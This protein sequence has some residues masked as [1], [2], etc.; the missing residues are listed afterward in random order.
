MCTL[1][2]CPWLSE[3][4]LVWLT[5][6]GRNSVVLPLVVTTVTGGGK[7]MYPETLYCLSTEHVLS[8]WGWLFPVALYG[9]TSLHYVP[10]LWLIS[11]VPPHN[12][13]GIL[14]FFWHACTSK[15]CIWRSTSKQVRELIF[16]AVSVYDLLPLPFSRLVIFILICCWCFL[17]NNSAIGN[18]G[19]V[20]LVSTTR[21]WQTKAS[22]SICNGWSLDHRVSTFYYFVVVSYF[23][24]FYSSLGCF[25]C[26]LILFLPQL[27]G[28]GSFISAAACR[29]GYYRGLHW[30]QVWPQSLFFSDRQGCTFI[31]YDHMH[32][33]STFEHE[34]LQSMRNWKQEG[35]RESA[36]FLSIH[37]GHL[38]VYGGFL[39]VFWWDRFV[40]KV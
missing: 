27:Q 25:A 36:L 19:Q 16:V 35:R 28:V 1:V 17:P 29:T 8:L 20:R 11:N 22:S 12:C 14:L 15:C 7:Y 18:D 24:F 39:S 38:V 31:A 10:E 30:L 2:D 3:F 34:Y 37:F 26:W 5:L 23:L 40:A 33:H 32:L 21:Q 6:S 9:G 13:S 4:E